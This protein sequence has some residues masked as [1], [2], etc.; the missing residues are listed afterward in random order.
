MVVI[1]AGFIIYTDS[2]VGTVRA[3]TSGKGTAKILT[4]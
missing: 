3:S 1:M 4:A 2:G